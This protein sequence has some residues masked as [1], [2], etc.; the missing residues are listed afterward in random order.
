MRTNLDPQ[1]Y[2]K[3]AIQTYQNGQ[4]KEAE[5]MLRRLYKK[6]PDNDVILNA[7]GS[8]LIDKKPIDASH[9]LKKATRINPKNVNAWVNYS[10]AQKKRGYI[11]EALELI[12]KA[13]EL[14]PEMIDIRFNEANI[15]MELQK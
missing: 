3:K 10:S 8:I 11:K 9:L 1:E 6:F 4:V 5:K 13:K 12:Q 2:F 15:Y 7:L 14:N